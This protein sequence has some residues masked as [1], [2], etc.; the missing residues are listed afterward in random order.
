MTFRSV[1]VTRSYEQVVEQLLERI[2]AGDFAP[3]ERL[4]TERE[5]GQMFGVSR[6]VIR[7]AIKVLGTLGVVESR[8]GSGTYVS[9]NLVPMVSRAL[10]L[11]ARPEEQSLLEL[12]EFRAPMERFAARLAAERRTD[13]QRDAIL[14]AAEATHR[15]IDNGGWSAFGEA[16]N[17]FHTAIYEAAGNPFLLTVMSAVREIQHNTVALVASS[18]GSIPVAVGH[19]QDIA[20]AI[21]D[22]DGDRAERCMAEHIAYSILAL[23]ATLALPPDERRT[24]D[25]RWSPPAF[26]EH[27][28][29]KPDL[30]AG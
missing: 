24:I 17:H 18:S 29:V 20:Q 11:A 7:E 21:A 4:P 23:R 22:G 19:H 12:M 8:Q 2:H 26:E 30:N 9:A 27:P 1:S 13:A 16:D 15:S 10:V 5:L 28:P 6:G 3:N 14:A 25:L